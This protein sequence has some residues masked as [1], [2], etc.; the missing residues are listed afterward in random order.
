MKFIAYLRSLVIKFFH[1]EQFA[2]EMDEEVRSHIELRAEDL[3]RS[4]MSLAEAERQAR[5]EFGREERVKEES[6]EALCGNFVDILM[7]DLRVSVRLLR[8]SPGFTTA[9][10]LTL[11]LAIGANAVVFG[12]MDGLVLQP[13]N[14]PQGETLWG[15]AY[16]EDP[17]FQ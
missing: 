5:I 7:Q 15:T 16:G 17:G 11:A 6:Y 10:V 2:E 14:V 13:L 4:G 1:R 8:K 12:L 9:A 3:G